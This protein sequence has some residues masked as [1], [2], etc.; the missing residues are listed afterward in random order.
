MINAT[1]QISHK[2]TRFSSL[3]LWCAQKA[4]C[5]CSQGSLGVCSSHPYLIAKS[6]LI[7]P[8]RQMLSLMSYDLGCSPHALR[9]LLRS[10]LSNSTASKP[11]NT[12]LRHGHDWILH[13][14]FRHTILKCNYPALQPGLGSRLEV[15]PIA[16]NS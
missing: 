14:T 9:E 2:P 8:V 15:G 16:L 4:L 6:L 12:L 10:A 3:H 5:N 7:Q 13:R 1:A 11:C